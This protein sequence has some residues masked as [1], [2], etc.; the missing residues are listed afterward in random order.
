MWLV[1]ANI[2]TP[3]HYKHDNQADG[4]VITGLT[5]GQKKKQTLKIIKPKTTRPGNFL[6]FLNRDKKKK[7][8]KKKVEL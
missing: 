4:A 2:S 3:E 8:K 6:L 1:S 7:K 5:P